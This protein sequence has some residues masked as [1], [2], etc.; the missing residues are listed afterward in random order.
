MREFFSFYF[1]GVC[2]GCTALRCHPPPIKG[3]GCIA[4]E[5]RFIMCAFIGGGRVLSL[6]IQ[7]SGVLLMLMSL[8]GFERSYNG[9]I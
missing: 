9:E 4:P 5:G 3:E 8:Q 6:L 7:R 1:D 2:C